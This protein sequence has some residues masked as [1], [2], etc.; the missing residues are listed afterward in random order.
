[1]SWA[2]VDPV[3]LAKKLE[4]NGA[5][6]SQETREALGLSD[7]P[8]RAASPRAGRRTQL[9]PAERQAA[10]AA[11]QDAP[12]EAEEKE[13]PLQ[14]LWADALATYGPDLPPMRS[15]YHFM[16]PW[17]N[18][19]FDWADLDCMIAVELDGGQYEAMGGRHNT[20]EDRYKLNC[21]A[22]LGWRVLRFSGSALRTE[23]ATCVA[24]YRRARERSKG[25][26]Q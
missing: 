24:L 13:N 18:S 15:E 23:P 20:D 4:A 26:L 2:D 14:R 25:V 19:R 10:I 5:R 7:A 22:A 1:M 21:A 9:T 3:A 12:A 6:Q 17:K 11:T 16:Q 8:A